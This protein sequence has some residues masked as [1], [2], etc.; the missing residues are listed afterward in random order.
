MAHYLKPIAGKCVKQTLNMTNDLITD[1]TSE[2]DK[3]VF[4]LLKHYQV[5]EHALR[6]MARS[7]YENE[8]K[9]GNGQNLYYRW[10]ACLVRLL[11]PI[12]IVE[13]GAAS[14]ISTMMMATELDKDAKLYS[15]DIDPAIAWKWMADDYPQVTKI[16]GDD[17]NMAIWPGN[18]DLG[19]T[20]IWF[21]DTLHYGYQLKRE[22]ETYKPY[23]K[24]G[25]IVIF[26]DIRLNDLYEI[27]DSLPYDKF[28][29][30]FPC[31]YS[32]FG[33]VKI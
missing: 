26:D 1:S 22:I 23:W 30:T 32:G 20:D 16:L 3:K 4:E 5:P 7:T 10:L 28:E 6:G 13:L 17:L 11:K 12:Q 19:K 21:I 25:A 33:F 8:V 18:V 2:I 29:N 31:H 9:N 14:G 24:R 27:W 15:V